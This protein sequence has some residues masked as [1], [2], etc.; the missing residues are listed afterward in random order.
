MR[1]EDNELTD[2]GSRNTITQMAQADDLAAV[3][4]HFNDTYLIEARQNS[5][6]VCPRRALIQD[7]RDHVS[8]SAAQI[9]HSCFTAR[10]PHALAPRKRAHGQSMTHMLHECRLTALTLGNH[11]RFSPPFSRAP[12]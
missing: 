8:Y 6:P 12:R 5:V 11:G 10:L 3:I 9:A 7:I 2:P 4:I 1:E